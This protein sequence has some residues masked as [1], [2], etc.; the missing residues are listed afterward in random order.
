MAAGEPAA[1][2]NLEDWREAFCAADR[3][4]V[5]RRD[6]RTPIGRGADVPNGRGRSLS[7]AHHLRGRRPGAPIPPPDIDAQDAWFAKAEDFLLSTLDKDTA[8]DTITA[9][10][11]QLPPPASQASEALADGLLPLPEGTVASP[12]LGREFVDVLAELR[13]ANHVNIY[14]AASFWWTLGGGDYAPHALCC[15]GLPD[16]FLFST[17]LTGRFSPAPEQDRPSG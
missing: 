5:R 9:A 13:G 6:G 16:P 4:S 3:N 12:A 10:L 2:R 1:A 14:A 8:Y 17:L 7:S 15:R 11:D